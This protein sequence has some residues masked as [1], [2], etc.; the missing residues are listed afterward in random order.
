[1]RRERVRQLDHEVAGDQLG[2]PGG[3]DPD[4]I[5]AIGRRA[6]D[7]ADHLAAARERHQR[8][9]DRDAA[10]GHRGV[11]QLGLLVA[12]RVEEPDRRARRRPMT[13]AAGGAQRERERHPNTLPASVRGQGPDHDITT[14]MRSM[15]GYGR[16]AAL[17]GEVRA[18]VD[19]RAVNHRFLDLKLRAGQ[20]SP[21]IEDAIA[22]RVR[23]AI[24]RG[25]V[26]V[27]V[28]AAGGAPGGM[29]IDADAATAAHRMLVELAQR[30]AIPGPDLALVLAQPGVVIADG[31]LDDGTAA[32]VL[33]A[34]DAAL[35]QLDAMRLAEGAALA[36]DLRLRLEQLGAARAQIALYAASVP[37]QVARRLTE[38]VKRLADDAGAPAVDDAR[39]AQEIALLADRAD[40]TEE[41]VRLA[42]HVDQARALVAAT[43][44]V[45]RRLDFLVQ[46]IGRELNTIG[47]KATTVEI[48]CAI[49][50]AKAALEK[51]REQVQNV[52]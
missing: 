42:S 14:A 13:G 11:E 7:L 6:Q 44:A 27:T 48:S 39:L 20:V 34:L 41:L 38:R 51:I 3:V 29:R 1:V 40:I 28:H 4:Q 23:G 19:I 16:G 33:E 22:I 10:L 8:G 49:V 21:A 24:E 32:V 52:E 47:A 37:H 5:R 17:R 30:L 43:G 31:A 18:T 35:A 9:L 46:E 45:G 25:S 26:A 2:Q 36:A 12:E 50:S 15:T